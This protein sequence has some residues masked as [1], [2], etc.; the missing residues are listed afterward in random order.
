METEAIWLRQQKALLSVCA[1]PEG[2]SSAL[3]A[4]IV[5]VSK[6][7]LGRF[8]ASSIFPCSLFVWRQHPVD[9]L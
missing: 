6:H 4:F 9:L 8:A 7:T 2:V 3:S 5:T 1:F